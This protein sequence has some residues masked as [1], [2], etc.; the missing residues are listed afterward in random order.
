MIRGEEQIVASGL[1]SAIL[2][3]SMIFGPGEDRNVSR[4]AAYLHR[5]RFIPAF[6][7]GSGLQQPIFVDDVV[8]VALS[9][10]FSTSCGTYQIAGPEPISYDRMIDLVGAAVGTNPVKI[11]LPPRFCALALQLAGKLGLRPGID[12]EQVM[13]LQEDKTASIEAAVRDFNFAPLSF[14]D[15]LARIYTTGLGEVRE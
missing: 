8:D 9:A 4:L 2:Q 1:P 10:L 15:A 11:H 7:D 3:S 13:R 12:R 14:N 6:G 5:W